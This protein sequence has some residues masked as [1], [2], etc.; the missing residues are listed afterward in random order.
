MA[1]C[2]IASFTTIFLISFFPTILIIIKDIKYYYEL[3]GIGGKEGDHHLGR[4]D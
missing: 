2:V 4:D 1:G 3:K